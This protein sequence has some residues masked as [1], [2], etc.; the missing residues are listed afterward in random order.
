MWLYCIQTIERKIP[1]K[2]PILKDPSVVEREDAEK[3]GKFWANIV[4]RDLPKHHKTF[5]LYH[6]K[7]SNDAKKFAEYCQ[8]RYIK[9][10]IENTLYALHMTL[11]KVTLI[12]THIIC[13]H[14]YL[15][16]MKLI[17]NILE[18]YLKI[19]RFFKYVNCNTHVYILNLGF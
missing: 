7:Q 9:I 10:S 19:L 18:I 11:S 2:H 1:K 12:P 3:I 13:P 14:S 15:L 6:R 4:K 5:L 17:F 16:Q 8:R